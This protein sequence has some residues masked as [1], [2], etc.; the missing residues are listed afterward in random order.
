MKFSPP[1]L[2]EAQKHIGLKEIAGVK[3]EPKIVAWWKAI[4]M[5]G[6]K[7][8]ET[9]YCAAF[10]GACLEE[11]GIV[12]TR[13]GW[14][15]DYLGWGVPLAV[16][17]L[18]AVVVFSRKGG[19][20]HVGFIS[21]LDERGR[22]MV[23]GGNQGDMVSIKPFDRNRVIGYR[24]PKAVPLSLTPLSVSKNNESSSTAEA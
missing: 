17:A 24:W 5:G 10:V 23:L 11:A 3:H 16:P 18:G 2:I 9:P 20:G 15:K 7:D 14:A 13:T 1:W 22:L 8:D 12:S 6:I 21:G 4:R 19:G